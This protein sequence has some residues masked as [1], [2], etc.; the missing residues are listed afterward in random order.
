MVLKCVSAQIMDSATLEITD[1]LKNYEL[2]MVPCKVRYDGPTEEF[3]NQ[4]KTDAVHTNAS[5]DDKA[6][7]YLRGR[8][9]IGDIINIGDRVAY[10]VQS[11]ED[12]SGQIS[13]ITTSAVSRIINYEREGNEERLEEELKRFEE[14]HQVNSILHG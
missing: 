8:K 11:K 7:T 9:L 5:H 12:T 4:L 3:V 6:V 14:L 1:D 10:L 2:H 13:I